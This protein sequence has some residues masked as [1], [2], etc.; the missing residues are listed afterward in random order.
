MET[1]LKKYN[2]SKIKYLQFSVESEFEGI[3]FQDIIIN[4]ETDRIEG[5]YLTLGETDDPFKETYNLNECPENYEKFKELLKPNFVL[6]AKITNGGEYFL[7]D[8][9]CNKIYECIGHIPRL[10]DFYNIRP[11]EGVYFYLCI[12]ENKLLR[13]SEENKKKGKVLYN[14]DDDW[15]LLSSNINLPEMSQDYIDGWNDGFMSLEAAMEDLLTEYI[16]KIVSEVITV[17]GNINNKTVN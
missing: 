17:L 1:T 5:G 13:V 11:S 10:M 15:N 8:E 6:C 4:L 3:K 7:L 12:K 14:S 2:Y 9:K 16:P